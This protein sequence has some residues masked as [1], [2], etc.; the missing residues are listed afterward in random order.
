MPLAL[1]A[2]IV[3][4]ISYGFAA[5]LLVNSLRTNIP[6]NRP[7]LLVVAIVGLAL[8]AYN[9]SESLFDEQGI[10][11][12][13]INVLSLFG[14]VLDACGTFITSFRDTVSLMAQSYPAACIGLLVNLM[15]HARVSPNLAM[16]TVMVSRILFS[17]FVY[18]VIGLALSQDVMLSIQIN[19]LMNRLIHD[20][21]H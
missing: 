19:Q 4:C 16:C 7:L 13:L 21:L 18:S 1:V 20:H 2:G 11:L 5:F 17:I 14:F 12:G 10:E 9:L 15:T 6:V 8:H 3:A